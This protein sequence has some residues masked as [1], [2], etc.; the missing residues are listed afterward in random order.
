MNSVFVTSMIDRQIQLAANKYYRPAQHERV[1]DEHGN[2]R[3]L[4]V[5]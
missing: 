5:E 3:K 4:E 1:N 2:Q